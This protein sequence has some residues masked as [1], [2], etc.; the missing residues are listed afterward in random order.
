MMTIIVFNSITDLIV[1]HG[2]AA[3]SVTR[4]AKMKTL[5]GDK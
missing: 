5:T 3:G 4:N 2:H 1:G